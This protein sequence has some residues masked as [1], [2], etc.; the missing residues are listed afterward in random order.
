M[1]LRSRL[2]GLCCAGVGTVRADVVCGRRT[3]RRDFMRIAWLAEAF[4]DVLLLARALPQMA[5]LTTLNL[6]GTN[7]PALCGLIA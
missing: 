2:L 4:A 7:S 5:Q 6:S 1:A 3:V